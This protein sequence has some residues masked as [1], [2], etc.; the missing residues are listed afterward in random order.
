MPAQKSEKRKIAD[1]WP[2]LRIS[3]AFQTTGRDHDQR[4]NATKTVVI[5][6]PRIETRQFAGV[7]M[8][9]ISIER[10]LL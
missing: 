3:N 9:G 2:T 7:A 4:I 5:A 10:P 1:G 8:E 6:S